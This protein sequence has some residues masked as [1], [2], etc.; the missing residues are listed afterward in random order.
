MFLLHG[1]VSCAYLVANVGLCRVDR[2]PWV[3][4]HTY[5]FNKKEP[6]TGFFTN[7]FKRNAEL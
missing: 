3:H 1:P 2:M 6:S 4:C 7:Y 5:M